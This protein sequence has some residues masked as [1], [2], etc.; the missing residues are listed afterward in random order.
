MIGL[1]GIFFPLG[2]VNLQAKCKEKEQC[3]EKGRS[4][5]CN[6]IRHQQ[7]WKHTKVNRP[8]TGKVWFKNYIVKINKTL[9]ADT[10]KI[11]LYETYP[12]S[13]CENL[14]EATG[15][16][17]RHAALFCRQNLSEILTWVWLDS[18]RAT[19]HSGGGW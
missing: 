7:C 5:S 3:R 1:S 6:H 11:F 9:I 8:F 14:A 12:C 18:P 15:N 17:S 2:E 4:L 19:R 16:M 10:K 13:L